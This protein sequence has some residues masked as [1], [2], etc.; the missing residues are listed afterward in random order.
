M[1]LKWWQYGPDIYKGV[2]IFDI[3]NALEIAE[4]RVQN[5]LKL[6]D[7]GKVVMDPVSGTI[8]FKK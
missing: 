1:K 8:V 7:E 4:K 5:G 2:D 3:D 6:Y